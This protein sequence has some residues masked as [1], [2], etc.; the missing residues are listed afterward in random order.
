VI[1][2]IDELSAFMQLHT[3]AVYIH[4]GDTYFVSELNTTER[5]A[6]VHRAELDY[7]TQAITDR[8]VQ[9]Q[10]VETEKAQEGGKVRFGEVSVTYITY[11]FKKI[12]FY[13]QDSI[14]FGKVSLPPSTLET[15]AFWLSPSLE[16]LARARQWGRNPKMACWASPMS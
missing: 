3:E 4:E 14:G 6:Y 1:G 12:K 5:A 16:T 8:R 10:D 9:V 2:S 7:Y 13:S 15:C 11:M